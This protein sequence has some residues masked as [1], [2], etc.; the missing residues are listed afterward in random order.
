MGALTPINA[1][2][3]N[4]FKSKFKTPILHNGYYIFLLM[5]AGRSLQYNKTSLQ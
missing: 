3:I 1:M 4:P 5:L 2:N